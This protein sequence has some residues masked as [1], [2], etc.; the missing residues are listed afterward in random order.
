MTDTTTTAR[1]EPPEP[2]RGVDGWHWLEVGG[3]QFCHR[4]WRARGEWRW[5]TLDDRSAAGMRH[6]AP[7]TPPAVVAALVEALEGC[8]DDLEAEIDY[9]YNFPGEN[10]PYPSENQRKRRDMVAVRNARAA[11]A[12][13]R[14][15]VGR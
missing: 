3:A 7:V 12:A 6:L 8:A 5:A 11:L 13:Y 1:C 9:R 14:G 2:L 15:A 10:S 4:W